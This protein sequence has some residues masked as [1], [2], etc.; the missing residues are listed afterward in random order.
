MTG[1]TKGRELALMLAPAIGTNPAIRAT[2]SKIC[3]HAATLH[4]LNEEACNGHPANADGRLPIETVTRLQDRWEERV[5]RETERT[6]KRLAALVL[7]LPWTTAGPWIFETQRD[8]RGR[9]TIAAPADGIISGNSWG[10]RNAVC[11]P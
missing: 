3:R 4:R 9:A 6:E 7:E 5:D 8:P 2:C 1:T 10:N 11:I